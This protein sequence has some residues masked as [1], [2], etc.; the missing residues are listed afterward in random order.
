M[1]VGVVWA[2]EGSL[3]F[4]LD[5]SS[6]IEALPTSGCSDTGPHCCLHLTGV[7]RVVHGL[8][9]LVLVV[10]TSCGVALHVGGAVCAGGVGVVRGLQS[11]LVL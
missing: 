4:P 8:S 3:Y 9:V 6:I 2:C 10:V 1:H 5:P 7:P 11:I